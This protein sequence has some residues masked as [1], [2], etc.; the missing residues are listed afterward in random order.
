MT[1]FEKVARG[2]TLTALAA[3][4]GPNFAAADETLYCTQ[5]ILSLPYQITAP[6]HYC[7][8]RNLSTGPTPSYPP[9]ITIG[10]DSVWL[11]LN[12]YTL[13]GSAVGS[14]T[15]V[16]GIL[17]TPNHSHVTVRNGVVRG[18]AAGI[19]LYGSGGGDTVEKIWADNNYENGI[20]VRGLAGSN[21]V[22][23]NVVTNT[24]G[25]TNLSNWPGGV[26]NAF[27][28][29]VLGASTVI[30]NQVTHTFGMNGGFAWAF[31]LVFE[32][33]GQIAVNNRVIGADLGFECG[34]TTNPVVVLRDNIVL[35]TPMPY[36]PR[37][38]KVGATNFP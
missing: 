30:D 29:S 12:N 33:E 1:S 25:S 32:G 22:R 27:G 3:L 11:D 31:E 35:T 5:Y 17:G 7:F 18:F 19:N 16:T 10:A 14:A 24:G 6:G 8:V 2:F 28:I 13:D 4:A 15:A 37:C 23:E 9:A 38:T 21:L 36:N 20:A 34:S 26:A